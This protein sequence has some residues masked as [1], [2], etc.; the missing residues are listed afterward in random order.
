[1]QPSQALPEGYTLTGTFDITQNARLVLLLNLLGLGLAALFAALFT[2]L[3]F[4]LRPAEAAAG[5][6]VEITHLGQIA[7]LVVGL[8]ALTA[9]MVVLHEAAHGLFFWLFTRSVPKFAFKGAYAYAAA[10][11]WYFPRRYYLVVGLAP[12]VLLSLAGCALMLVIPP[13]WFLALVFFLVSNAAGAVGD[14]WVMGWLA[15][16][17]SGV[18]AEDRGDAV[19]LYNKTLD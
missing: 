5:F 11:G 15:L 14:L 4:A 17:K 3:L 16:Q 9:A 13:A 6:S 2:S 7:G 8:I 10:P 18:L 1:M 12:L 19:V